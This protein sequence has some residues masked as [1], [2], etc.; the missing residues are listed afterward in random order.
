MPVD[1]KIRL[2]WLPPTELPPTICDGAPSRLV[3]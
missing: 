1:R 3:G 2:E